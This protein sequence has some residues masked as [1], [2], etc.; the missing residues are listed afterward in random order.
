M[1]SGNGLPTRLDI[2]EVVCEMD[3]G[4]SRVKKIFQKWL[5]F[6]KT[7]R[8]FFTQLSPA[9]KPLRRAHTEVYIHISTARCPSGSLELGGL[10][11]WIT[12][13]KNAGWWD[14]R[15]DGGVDLS[16]EN[17]CVSL[18]GAHISSLYPC[19]P[20]LCPISIGGRTNI[21]T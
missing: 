3:Y 13:G 21:A 8:L 4:Y 1:P 15:A 20:P 19:L 17:A 18:L 2:V 7:W 14:V 9:K 16:A 6:V 10:P 11:C 5:R 12:S